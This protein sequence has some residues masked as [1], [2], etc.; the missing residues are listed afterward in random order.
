MSTKAKRIATLIKL[1]FLPE[2]TVTLVAASD[3]YKGEIS[4]GAVELLAAVTSDDQQRVR[5]F[6]LYSSVVPDWMR[7]LWD[8]LDL[9][10]M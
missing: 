1:G 6:V 2:S 9:Q 4:L 10:R 8:S 5:T 7:R 3:G